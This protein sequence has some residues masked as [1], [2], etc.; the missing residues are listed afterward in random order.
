M[1]NLTVIT[2]RDMNFVEGYDRT[3]FTNGVQ[4]LEGT[5]GVQYFEGYKRRAIL[6]GYKRRA[7]I[8]Y[9]NT[10]LLCYDRTNRNSPVFFAS[11]RKNNG[12]SKKKMYTFYF[13]KKNKNQ[14]ELFKTFI[15]PQPHV[16][17]LLY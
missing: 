10:K 15:T 7:T 11:L 3:K 16:S 6:E 5:N 17:R 1:S 13:K 4:I 12:T 14:T 9:A 2:V 8:V